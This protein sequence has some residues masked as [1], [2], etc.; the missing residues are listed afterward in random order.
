MDVHYYIVV[1]WVF[2]ANKRSSLG[3]Y[4]NSSQEAVFISSWL[5]ISL[6]SVNSVAAVFAPGLLKYCSRFGI[7]LIARDVCEFF[8]KIIREAMEARDRH[9]EVLIT[10]F[11]SI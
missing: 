8:E 10:V 1:V 11:H 4:S 9:T 2:I 5:E 7:N 6:S 3:R